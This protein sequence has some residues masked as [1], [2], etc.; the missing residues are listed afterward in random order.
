MAVTQWKRYL[1]SAPVEQEGEWSRACLV[2]MN[3]RFVE[4][5]SREVTPRN[6]LPLSI[7]SETAGGPPSAEVVMAKADQIATSSSDKRAPSIRTNADGR[8]TRRYRRRRPKAVSGEIDSS[9]VR[10][11]PQAQAQAQDDLRYRLDLVRA[12]CELLAANPK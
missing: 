8:T 6:T 4:A 11:R 7:P 5:C 9:H 10:E 1:R 2:E 3:Q 12:I